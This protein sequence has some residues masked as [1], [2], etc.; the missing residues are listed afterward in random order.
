MPR[1]P[2]IEGAVMKRR[3]A[4]TPDIDRCLFYHGSQRGKKKDLDLLSYLA[5]LVGLGYLWMGSLSAGP[6]AGSQINFNCTSLASLLD[7]PLLKLCEPR[8]GDSCFSRV[9][10][11][12]LDT[13]I[14]KD[15]G[16]RQRGARRL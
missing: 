16:K 12:S 2:M 9:L 10:P 4:P 14:N 3:T 13:K 15:G 11:N 6:P 1:L 5:G 7:F 8:A